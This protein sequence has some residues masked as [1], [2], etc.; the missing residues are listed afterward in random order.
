MQAEGK[1]TCLIPATVLVSYA[2][3]FVNPA[4]HVEKRAVMLAL[5]F[6]LLLPSPVETRPNEW[7]S[8]RLGA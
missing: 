2:Y 4:F 7:M 1:G 5:M 8:Q 3:T 6:A